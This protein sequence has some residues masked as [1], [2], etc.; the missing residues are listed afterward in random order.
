MP[1]GSLQAK[2]PLIPDKTCPPY[3]STPKDLAIS[4]G[5]TVYG[6]GEFRKLSNEAWA[7]DDDEDHYQ[8]AM[9]ATAGLRP[10]DGGLPSDD[11][12]WTEIIRRHF[13]VNGRV[14]LDLA[15]KWKGGG[16]RRRPRCGRTQASLVEE[17][18]AA[19]KREKFL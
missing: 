18:E 12:I 10:K 13:T 11:C 15:R 16:A 6:Y 14:V 1:W 8:E 5:A 7:G 2:V 3:K 4:A 17:L 19:L 9:L